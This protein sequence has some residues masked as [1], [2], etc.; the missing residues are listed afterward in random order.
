VRRTE[1]SEYADVVLPVAPP[2]EKSGT[3]VN[4]EG[5]LRSF[6]TAIRTD[7]ISDHRA[8]DVLAREMGVTLNVGT[9]R[10]IAAELTALA[11]DPALRPAEPK[12]KSAASAEGLVL[13]SWHHLVDEGALQDGEPYL[14]GTGRTSVARMSAATAAEHKVGAAVTIKGAH[15]TVVELPVAITDM[16]DGVVWVPTKSPGS[17]VARDL[18]VEPGGNVTVQGVNG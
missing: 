8:L 13:A 10:E 4:W 15:R 5:R 16:A 2:S 17:W 7:A 3:F 12:V 14:A 9:V 18:G 1:V 11:A 6:A